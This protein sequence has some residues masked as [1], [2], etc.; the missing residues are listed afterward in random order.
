MVDRLYQARGIAAPKH[1]THRADLER[2]ARQGLLTEHGPDH[3]RTYTLN[4]WKAGAQ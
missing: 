2:L 4:R 3:N 1:S